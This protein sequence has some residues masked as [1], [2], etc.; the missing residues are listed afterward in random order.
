[1]SGNVVQR[2]S[3]ALLPRHQ[4]A[5]EAVQSGADA[6]FELPAPCVLNN[7]AGF[8]KAG[9]SMA[10]SLGCRYLAFGSECGDTGLLQ[11]AA[12]ATLSPAYERALK[13]FLTRGLSFASASREAMASCS[14]LFG[15]VLACPN[16]LLGIEYLKTIRA[17]NAPLMPL[18]FTRLGSRYTDTKITPNAFP[19]SSSLRALLQRDASSELLPCA[20][21]EACALGVC[22]SD[23][24]K[25]AST[26]LTLLRRLPTKELALCADVSEGLEHRLLK[27]ARES[28]TLR[29]FFDVCATKRYPAARLRRIVL[30]AT[31]GYTVQDNATP[32]LYARLLAAKR[33]AATLWENASIP[34]V[35]KPAR[36]ELSAEATHQF[37]L[38]T[39]S[40]DLFAFTLPRPEALKTDRA[41]SPLIF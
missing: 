13:E 23:E 11:E 22:P 37:D 18:T 5:A 2:G 38:N 1:M 40:C 10:V 33:I 16:N 4:R 19:S 24:E 39:A 15:E 12:D 3:F 41:L 21:K 32:P 25:V 30:N 8:A 36:A 35:I 14:P 28:L 17:L 26:V 31:L 20:L 6:V 29:D 27:A 34:V 7:A 9:V